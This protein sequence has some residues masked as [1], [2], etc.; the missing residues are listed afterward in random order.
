MA[1]HAKVA[2][3]GDIEASVRK[4]LLDRAANSHQTFL[5]FSVERISVNDTKGVTS[6]RAMY[7]TVAQSLG[8]PYRQTLRPIPSM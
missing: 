5:P 7:R 3:S 6:Y 1:I 2:D 4:F 8:R